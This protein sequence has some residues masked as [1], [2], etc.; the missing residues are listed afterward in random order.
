[1]SIARSITQF[2]KQEIDTL[3]K[4]ARRVRQDQGV[5][6]LQSPRQSVIG[7]ILIVIPRKIGNAPRRNKLRRQIKSIFYEKNL[8]QGDYDWVI[9][10]KPPAEHLTFGKLQ[11]FFS[12][13]QSK[14]STTL[15]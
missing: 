7:R 6:I 1:M 15:L 10:L 4:T 8:Y 13:Y 3:F 5:T 12:S 2:T 9:L 14:S 11:E